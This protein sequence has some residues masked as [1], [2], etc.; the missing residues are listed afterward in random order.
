[1]YQ[2]LSRPLDA[3]GNR[4]EKLAAK[5]SAMGFANTNKGAP[6]GTAQGFILSGLLNIMA[7]D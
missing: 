2:D 3:S 1:V 7:L 6:I 4:R 5:L